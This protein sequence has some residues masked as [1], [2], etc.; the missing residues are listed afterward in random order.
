MSELT[1]QIKQLIDRIKRDIRAVDYHKD[2]RTFADTSKKGLDRWSQEFLMLEHLPQ[3]YSKELYNQGC[4]ATGARTKWRIDIDESIATLI[5]TGSMIKFVRMNDQWKVSAVSLEEKLADNQLARKQLIDEALEFFKQEQKDIQRNPRRA[6]GNSNTA[7]KANDDS[8]GRTNKAFVGS[9]P[10]S[11]NLSLTAAEQLEECKKLRSIS[12]DK[13]YLEILI[14][15]DFERL[16][17]S[18]KN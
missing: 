8:E 4:Y 12:T 13:V 14:K 3:L 7:N 17:L 10:F 18:Q 1:E 16:R 6:M 2:I 11:V 9:T 5:K 15:E